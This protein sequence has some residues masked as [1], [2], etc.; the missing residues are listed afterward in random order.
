MHQSP[1]RLGRT[2]L[3]IDQALDIGNNRLFSELHIFILY[4][5]F[6]FHYFGNREKQG[7][8]ISPSKYTGIQGLEASNSAHPLYRTKCTLQPSKSTR[9]GANGELCWFPIPVSP[10]T[11]LRRAHAK[12][13]CVLV[14]QMERSQWNGCNLTLIAQYAVLPSAADELRIDHY[15]DFHRVVPGLRVLVPVSLHT[16]LV[17]DDHELDWNRRLEGDPTI[18]ETLTVATPPLFLLVYDPI[19]ILGNV[20]SNL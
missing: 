6:T 9:I 4:A 7:T 16:N 8:S 20:P 15:V 17:V 19:L 11:V 3:S 18:A 1:N 10:Q 14:G 13:M 12:Q 2:S 5:E